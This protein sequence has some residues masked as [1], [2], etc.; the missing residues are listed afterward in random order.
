MSYFGPDGTPLER[1]VMVVTLCG[2]TR[3]K[4][5]F[6][7]VNR[8]LTLSGHLVFA[9]G[10][11]GHADGIPLTA[12]QKAQLD[13]LHLEKIRRSDW[14]YVINPGGYIG[15]STRREIEYATS[16]GKRI[17]YTE[18]PTAE[19]A[20]VVG[21]TAPGAADLTVPRDLLESLAASDDCWLD[22][23][24]GCQSHGYLSLKPGEVCPQQELKDLLEGDGQGRF[25]EE[26]GQVRDRIEHALKSFRTD[27]VFS[28]PELIG[29]KFERL[30]DRVRSELDTLGDNQGE[31]P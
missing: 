19:H 29:E 6:E 9:P 14:V 16:T 3:F 27:M 11:F 7:A 15:E 22:H 30:C 31:Q 1:R 4:A 26:I 8:G 18:E 23:H 12:E 21:D 28:A 24:G 13:E 5:E 2:S 25:G 17:R 10:V 20:A